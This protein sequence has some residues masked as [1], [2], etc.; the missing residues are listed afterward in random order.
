[1]INFF[2]LVLFFSFNSYY[3]YIMRRLYFFSF[4][5]LVSSLFWPA[6]LFSQEQGS[7]A[8]IPELLRRPMRGEAPRYPRDM[9]IGELGQ[10]TAP[11]NAWQYAQRI[12][13]F[14]VSQNQ[15]NPAVSEADS[16]TL[17]EYL[18]V[19]ESFEPRTYHLGGGR[20][21][22]DGSVSFLVRFIGREQWIAGELYLYLEG[23]TWQMDELVLEELRT[24]E[25]GRSSYSFNFSPYE[26]FY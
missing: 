18:S 4:V 24:M 13:A 1:M 2:Y 6:Y 12:A 25:E 9:V 7:S 19:M 5:L 15:N 16:D 22:V 11:D 23:N 20:T 10:G 26:R 3:Y 14:L 17:V 8:T 21:E